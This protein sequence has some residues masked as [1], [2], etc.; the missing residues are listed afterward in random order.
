M[1]RWFCIKNHMN[2]K[3]FK[4]GGDIKT[5]RLDQYSA[6]WSQRQRIAWQKMSTA[7]L[8]LKVVIEKGVM[9]QEC[10]ISFDGNM[11]GV[12][13][14]ILIIHPHVCCCMH[15][16]PLSGTVLGVFLEQK[17]FLCVL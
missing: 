15:A 16:I 9:D 13:L 12:V 11:S 14:P 4:T 8:A 17:A 7:N 10:L 6:S 2:W 3:Y 1:W 5:S